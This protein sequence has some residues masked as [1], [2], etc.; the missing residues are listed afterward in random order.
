M[1]KIELQIENKFLNRSFWSQELNDETFIIVSWE[2]KEFI[3][4]KMVSGIKLH[5]SFHNFCK[6]SS[7]FP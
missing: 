6:I 2:R 4:I 3:G 1:L 7:I 5:K